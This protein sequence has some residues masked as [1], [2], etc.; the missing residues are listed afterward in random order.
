M[1]ACSRL[2]LCLWVAAWLAVNTQAAVLHVREGASGANT[3]ATWHDAFIDLQAALALATAGDQILVATGTYKPTAGTDPDCAFVLKPGVELYGSYD[4]NGQRDWLNQP[5][6]LS[7]EIRPGDQP[8]KSYHVMICAGDALLDGFTFCGGNANGTGEQTRGGGILHTGGSLTVRNCIFTE[9][10][11]IVGGAIFNPTTG[12][13]TISNSTFLLNKS[14]NEAGAIYN[15]GVLVAQDCT[16]TRN[17][18][19]T[20]GAILNWG[21]IDITRSRFQL[22]RAHDKIGGAIRNLYTMNNNQIV[23]CIFDQNQVGV[24]YVMRGQ[25]IDNQTS[26]LAI[27]GTRFLSHQGNYGG[28]SACVY[29]SWGQLDIS[30]CEFS[31]NSTA[32]NNENGIM[33]VNWSLFYGNLSTGIRQNRGRLRCDNTWFMLTRGNAIYCATQIPTIVENCFFIDN[34][35]G[36]YNAGVGNLVIKYCIFSGNGG[37]TYGGG[38]VWCML[39]TTTDISECIFANNRASHGSGIANWGTVN[40]S[41]STMAG[42]SAETNGANIYSAN[43]LT[44]SD[45]IIDGDNGSSADFNINTSKTTINNT[46]LRGSGGSG[47]AWHLGTDGGG[48]IDGDPLFLNPQSPSGIDGQ[49]LT[50]VD[51]LTLRPGSPAIGAGNPFGPAGKD[52][53]NRLRVFPHDIGAYIFHRSAADWLPYQ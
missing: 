50:A 40:L 22:N 39:G 17:E 8:I 2:G 19:A 48:N 32:L 37:A 52:I 13:L 20:A 53:L 3:G 11:A 45:C 44:I 29:N 16:F 41:R 36:I 5:T 30:V 6:I 34:A 38:G 26:L 43:L 15:N 24:Q 47:S 28:A 9:N 7:G 14:V 10:S 42:N 12:T 46:L 49:W 25:A 23:D 31:N 33:N 21:R 4:Q 1:R 27:T 35:R 51:G 18:S